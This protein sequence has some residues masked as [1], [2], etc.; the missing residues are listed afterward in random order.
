MEKFL[1]VLKMLFQNEGLEEKTFLEVKTIRD[2]LCRQYGGE[3]DVSKQCFHCDKH[4]RLAQY[5]YQNP[6]DYSWN[7]NCY[8]GGNNYRCCS[9]QYKY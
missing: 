1:H 7:F 5:E 3:L 4:I 2:T 6:R 9:R 8:F